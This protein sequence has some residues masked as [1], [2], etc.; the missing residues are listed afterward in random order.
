[1]AAVDRGALVAALA[2]IAPFI[3]PYA[4]PV[5]RTLADAR[6]S[7]KRILFEGA[8]AVLLD[9]DHGTYPFVTSSNVVA[10]SAAAGSGLGPGAL[11]FVLGIVKAYTT[12]VGSGPFPTELDDAIGQRL[13]ERGR[14]FGTV[15]GRKRRCGWFDAV[16]VRQA[17]AVSGVTGMALTKLDVLDG[18]E[19]LSICT[20]YR[21]HGETLDYFPA[22]AADQAAVRTDLRTVRGM[23]RI[24]RRRA[25]LG[26]AP[27]ASDQVHPPHRGADQL[28][29]GAGEHLTR[30]RGH[31]FSQ[32]PVFGLI[33]RRDVDSPPVNLP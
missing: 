19:T 1:M 22:H 13:G 16:L 8:Q 29:G 4:A 21:L 33:C 15:T 23:E 32:G 2:D 3:L 24:D 30:A 28:P 10:G 12:R 14:E 18:L 25:Q 17:V 5:W 9:V 31:D 26:T 27:R 7:G 6:R 11:N 20:G